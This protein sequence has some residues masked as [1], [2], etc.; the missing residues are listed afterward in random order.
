VKEGV[1]KGTGGTDK[2]SVGLSKWGARDRS[3]LRTGEC[4]YESRRVALG[5][6][7]N[8]EASKSLRTVLRTG[9]AG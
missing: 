8:Y 2:G 7:K 1:Q 6:K 5:I 4:K 9:A 3:E